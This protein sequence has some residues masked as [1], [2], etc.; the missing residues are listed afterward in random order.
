MDRGCVDRRL[1]AG[2][3][4]NVHVNRHA[5]RE[6]ESVVVVQESEGESLTERFGENR[7]SGE[8][9]NRLDFV[10]AERSHHRDVPD[11]STVSERNAVDVVCEIDARG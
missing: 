10:I 5:V 8:I 2:R 11:Q 3:D 4:R 9:F 7:V 1:I 6:E